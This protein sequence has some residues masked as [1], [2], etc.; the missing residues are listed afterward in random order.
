MLFSPLK[1]EHLNIVR[2]EFQ[3]ASKAL[4]HHTGQ[5]HGIAQWALG[6]ERGSLLG[7]KSTGLFPR[8]TPL[9]QKRE[10]SQLSEAYISSFLSLDDISARGTA[11]FQQALT[12]NPIHSTSLKQCYLKPL[13]PQI[14]GSHPCSSDKMLVFRLANGNFISNT[15]G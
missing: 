15:P 2:T 6:L 12:K 7:S 14:P 10:Q 4:L 3:L 1:W 13:T 11:S 9:H 8:T 5:G